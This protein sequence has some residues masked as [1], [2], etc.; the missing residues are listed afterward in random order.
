MRL[1]KITIIS[2]ILTLCFATQAFAFGEPIFCPTVSQIN[3]QEAAGTSKI[4]CDSS[5]MCV[6]D[7]DAVIGKGANWWFF[8]DF[9]TSSNEEAKTL[10]Q[11]ELQSL[12]W[13]SGPYFEGEILTCRYV[14][15]SGFEGTAFNLAYIW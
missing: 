1:F 11:N 6:Y 15:R 5:N 2:T 8:M 9:N 13:K 4:R 12:V 3:A 14:T 7:Q 10:T